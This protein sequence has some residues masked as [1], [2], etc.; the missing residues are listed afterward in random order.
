MDK[1]T[2]EE[3][4]AFNAVKDQLKLASYSIEQDATA[5]TLN[6][7]HNAKKSKVVLGQDN[8]ATMQIKLTLTAGLLDVSK[9]KP[10]NEL[11]DGG[12]VPSGAFTQ[13]EKLL[14][15]QITSAFEKCRLCGCDAF[16]IGESLQKHQNKRYES[17]KATAL[18]NALLDIQV[19]F[20][21]IR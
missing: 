6:I 20:R 21:N 13:A 4:F 3:T 17:V 9:A 1:F 19:T 10:L 15:A 2:T 8:R 12:N 14:T 11:R 5:C 18:K 7:K 16:G